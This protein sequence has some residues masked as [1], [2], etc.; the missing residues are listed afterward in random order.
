MMPAAC[1]A[2]SCDS[3]GDGLRMLV[4]D[5]RRDS[6]G[7]RILEHVE[8]RAGIAIASSPSAAADGARPAEG[9]EFQGANG[10]REEDDG[11]PQEGTGEVE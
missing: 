6:L 10:V 1:T 2:S 9:K 5:K 4:A 8:T 7:R 3:Q 11:A